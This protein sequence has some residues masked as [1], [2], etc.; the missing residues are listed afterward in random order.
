ML[1]RADAVLTSWSYSP[2]QA[3]EDSGELLARVHLRFAQ[4]QWTNNGQQ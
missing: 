3:A 4:K 1:M 2:N